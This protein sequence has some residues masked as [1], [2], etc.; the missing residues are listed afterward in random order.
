MSKIYICYEKET[1]NDAEKA[2]NFLMELG[3]EVIY[4]DGAFYMFVKALEDSAVN[5]SKVA[6]KY[7]LLLVP[8]DSFGVNGY[9]RL[10]YCV[11]KKT[12]V[13]SMKAFKELKKEYER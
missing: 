8:S 6:L 3:Y 9:V 1:P 4:P 13:N 10:A 12:I 11:S 2:S 5:F 7:D